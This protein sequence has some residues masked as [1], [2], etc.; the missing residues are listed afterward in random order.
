MTA[1]RVL[2]VDDEV[3]L[4]RALVERMRLRGIDAEGVTTGREALDRIDQAN[5]DV[6]LLDVKMPGIDGLQVIRVAKDR[7]PDLQVV[8]LTGH[9]ASENVDEGRR[10]GAFDCLMKPIQIDRLLKVLRAASG[11]DKL[12]GR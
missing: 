8:L 7:H 1:L 10:L 6:V 2:V 11:R 12:G 4:V 3:Q 9:G 5:F